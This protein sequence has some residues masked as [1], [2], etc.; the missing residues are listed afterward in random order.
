MIKLLAVGAC[1]ASSTLAIA[2]P[3]QPTI[4]E[5]K[6]YAADASGKLVPYTQDITSN[7]IVLAIK[8]MGEPGSTVPVMFTATENLDA[9]Y[10]EAG[11]KA[12][13]KRKVKFS[14]K[15]QLQGET[16]W[17]LLQIDLSC[18]DA[19]Q[20]V[21]GKSKQELSFPGSCAI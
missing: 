19:S 7:E 8:V 2:A 3:K 1:L 6:T 10:A 5:V 4:A 15:A 20:I 14:R 21:V 17:I 16:T 9:Q 11:Q 13:P 18:F 12:P